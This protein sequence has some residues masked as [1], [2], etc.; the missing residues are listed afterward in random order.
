MN[1]ATSKGAERKE[2]SFSNTS[3]GKDEDGELLSDPRQARDYI[4]FRF[5]RL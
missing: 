5:S 1:G 4:S 2:F 3:V